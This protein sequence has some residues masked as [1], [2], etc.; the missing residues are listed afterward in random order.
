MA[1]WWR[2]T[3]AGAIVFWGCLSAYLWF[4]QSE[5]PRFSHN[6]DIG[7]GRTL[8]V[9]SIRRGDWIEVDP[10]TVYYRVDEGGREVIQTTWLDHDDGSEY[11]FRMVSANG[12]RLVCVYE[13]AR[14]ADND[15][16]MLIYDAQRRE[17]WPRARV[18]Y[19]GYPGEAS[20]KWRERFRR[21]KA[22]NPELPAPRSF[23]E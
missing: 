15:F 16:L 7:G 4:V 13:V 11:E 1:K 22:E 2:W 18:E 14:A 10:L 12:G 17:S 19:G 21:L 5:L 20:A 9:W 23:V 8:T 3:A 6:F